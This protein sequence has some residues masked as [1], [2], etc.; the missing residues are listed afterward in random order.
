MNNVEVGVMLEGLQIE[1]Y[2][3]EVVAL[4]PKTEEELVEKL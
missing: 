3:D 1:G 2:D 4:S